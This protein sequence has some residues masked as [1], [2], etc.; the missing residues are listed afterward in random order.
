MTC[1]TVGPAAGIFILR[2]PK[3]HRYFKTSPLAAPF[4]WQGLDESPASRSPAEARQGGHVH[5][6]VTLAPTGKAPASV[7]ATEIEPHPR[8]TAAFRWH[9]R[10][11]F[12]DE[13]ISPFQG[14]LGCP[15]LWPRALP[16]AILLCPL[17][18]KRRP[19]D[20]ARAG[21]A[22]GGGRGSECRVGGCSRGLSRLVPQD[23][24]GDRLLRDAGGTELQSDAG[25]IT[26][27][28]VLEE[29]GMCARRKEDV[30][31]V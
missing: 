11:G 5:A 19:P 8:C 4:W 26:V 10:G 1:P 29:E 24:A 27:L 23:V 31:L 22:T 9:A 6:S 14:F 25:T 28:V 30:S 20:V 21:L 17:R 18:A 15:G 3:T 7:Y 13:P 2:I 12:S 16:W